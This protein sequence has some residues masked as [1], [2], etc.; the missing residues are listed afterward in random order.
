MRRYV[1]SPCKMLAR[2]VLGAVALAACLAASARAGQEAGKPDVLFLAIEDV[3]P[4][5]FG[6]W[7]NT[8]CQTPHIDKLAEEGV[9]FDRAHC[10]APPCNPSRTA[11]LT[12]LRPT[13]TEVYGNGDDWRQMLPGVLTMP[14]HLRNCGYQTVRIGKIFHG[15]FEHDASWSR[16]VEPFDGL[17]R[18]SKG[19]RKLMGPGVA[20]RELQD[21]MRRQRKPV[22]KGVPF[23]YGP[24]GLDDLEEPDGAGAEQAVRILRAKQDKP[25]FLALGFHKPHLAFTAPD[26]YFKMYPADEMVLPP[27][28]EDDAADMPHT[29]SLKEQKTFTPRMWREAIAAEYACLTFIDA[30]VGRVLEA[31]EESGRA[32]DTIVV[33]WSDHGFMLG[34]HF[35]WRKGPRY[36]H[37]DQVAL[38]MKV[39]GVTTPGTVCKRPVESF[40]IFPTLFD[41]CGLPMPEGIEGISMK[42]LLE[43]P[44]RPWKK[45]AIIGGRR[46]SLSIRTER[47]RYTEYG[48]PDR[49]ELFDYQ[50]DPGEYTN[51]VG[52]P[53]YADTLAKLR[54]LLHA[55]PKACLP[56]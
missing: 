10:M 44:D 5:R 56:D 54:D 46:G 23:L 31:L 9:R 55:G 51:L 49:A 4:H 29:P 6:C 35:M 53:K 34:E 11:L 8:V 2:V 21:R 33:L 39:P 38:I 17:A 16:V 50:I 47:Y 26:K 19:R 48:G 15:K 3:S 7:G 1:N 36:D 41:L 12:S 13:T 42:P 52:D 25:L 24:S 14:Q 30:Q 28:P 37:S 20:L 22:P 18:P 32:E 43:N 45:G 27:V 40:D